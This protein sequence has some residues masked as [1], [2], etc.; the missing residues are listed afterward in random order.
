MLTPQPL[1]PTPLV[2]PSM[3]VPDLAW[4]PVP[5]FKRVPVPVRVH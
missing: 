1:P 2:L 3:R 5:P 4:V